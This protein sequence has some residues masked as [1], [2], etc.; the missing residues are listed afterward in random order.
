MHA[1]GTRE[2]DKLGGL[3]KLMPRTAAAFLVGS[4][5]ICG[6]PPLNGF[7]SEFM[8]YYG[9]FAGTIADGLKLFV[10]ALLVI[11]SLA[12]IGGLALACFTKA[13][14]IIFL[15]EPR[16]EHAS[17]AHEA[18]FAM[19]FSMWVLAALCVDNRPSLLLL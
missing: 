7:I 4:I 1:T 10:P 18:G 17:K 9:A 5:A 11:G 16:S 12:L 19:Q 2:I 14:G 13:Y 15:G 3:G 6:L 8:I